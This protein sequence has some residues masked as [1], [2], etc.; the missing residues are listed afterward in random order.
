MNRICPAPVY[1]ATADEHER[2]V[3]RQLGVGVDRAHVG[4]VAL[5]GGEVQ[6]GVERPRIDRGV[7]APDERVG[8]SMFVIMVGMEV[9]LKTF[10]GTG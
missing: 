7:G 4:P 9:L 2:L 3:A 1:A 6:D 8:A 10:G 5:R